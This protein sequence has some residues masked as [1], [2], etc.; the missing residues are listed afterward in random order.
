MCS[1]DLA[2]AAAHVISNSLFAANAPP[3]AHNQIV[4]AVALLLLLGAMFLKGYSEVVS[5]ATVLVI[6]FLGLS[7]LIVASSLWYL[8]THPA[9]LRQ[10]FSEIASGTYHLHERPLEGHGL[11]VAL[12]ISL[13]IF[14][15]LALGLSGLDRK[16]T[17]LNSSH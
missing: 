7:L 13:L 14:P 15:K 3:W 12:G 4:L 8:I 16:S 10:W 11:W 2:D 5:I 17:R 9:L 6:A 1:S